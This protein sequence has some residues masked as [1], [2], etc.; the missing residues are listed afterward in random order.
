MLFYEDESVEWKPQ[1][2]ADLD[3]WKREHN[4][5]A[6]QKIH[7]LLRSIQEHGL[8]KGIGHA[9]PMKW[10]DEEVWSRHIDKKNRLV[11][12]E[13]DHKSQLQN[14][15]LQFQR[16]WQAAS[17]NIAGRDF[18]ASYMWRCSTDAMSVSLAALDADG[19]V[20]GADE[21]LGFARSSQINYIFVQGAL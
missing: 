17:R 13:V 8:S 14:V 9:K 7:D 4:R 5:R 18:G 2:D 15:V 1:A 11:Y 16:S 20:K 19:G 10:Y 3:E 6:L 12:G 21:N